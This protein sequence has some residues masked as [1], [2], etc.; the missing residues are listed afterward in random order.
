MFIPGFHD[1]IISRGAED[2][3]VCANCGKTVDEA[4][5]CEYPGHCHGEVDGQAL[6]PSDAY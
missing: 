6:H 2:V 3:V 1:W 4:D 5:E